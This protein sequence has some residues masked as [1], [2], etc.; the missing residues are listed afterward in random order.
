MVSLLLRPPRANGRLSRP[1][2]H[3]LDFEFPIISGSFRAGSLP[4]AFLRPLWELS[5]TKKPSPQKGESLAL[6]PFFP[7]TS[8]CGASRPPTWTSRIPAATRCAKGAE[9]PRRLPRFTCR[10]PLSKPGRSLVPCRRVLLLFLACRFVFP[11]DSRFPA[12]RKAPFRAVRPAFFR[13]RRARIFRPLRARPLS[14]RFALCQDFFGN[15]LSQLRH[16][17]CTMLATLPASAT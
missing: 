17:Y 1:A 13:F 12:A 14:A 5:K 15:I 16:A 4:C 2:R 7:R 6:P 3:F 11:Y 8:L 9:A 10:R